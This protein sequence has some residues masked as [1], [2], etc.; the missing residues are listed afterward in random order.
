[1][2]KQQVLN[3]YVAGMMQR[4]LT[5]LNNILHKINRITLDIMRLQPNN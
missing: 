4:I 3:E 1:M 2:N 5:I